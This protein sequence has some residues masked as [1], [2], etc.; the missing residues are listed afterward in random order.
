[1]VAP[2]V[3]TRD[4][5]VEQMAAYWVEYLDVRMAAGSVVS[6]EQ[7]AVA[8]KDKTKVVQMVAW[9]EE[10]MVCRQVVWSVFYW[11]ASTVG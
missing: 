8:Q 11:V 1:M 6:M 4:T 10:K 7:K 9:S 5:M 3:S 2:M